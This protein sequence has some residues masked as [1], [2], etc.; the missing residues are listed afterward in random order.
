MGRYGE[1]WGG[2]GRYG[3]VWGGMGGSTRGAAAPESAPTSTPLSAASRPPAA[4]AARSTPRA[5]RAGARLAAATRR[6]TARESRPAERERGRE[7]SARVG[8]LHLGVRDVGRCGE[9]WGGSTSARRRVGLAIADRHHTVRCV[10]FD[11]AAMAP[12][13]HPCMKSPDDTRAV[14]RSPPATRALRGSGTYKRHRGRGGRTALYARL[15]RAPREDAGHKNTMTPADHVQREAC[16]LERW[17]EGMTTVS[18]SRRRR[19]S[20]SRRHPAAKCRPLAPPPK[21][22]PLPRPPLRPPPPSNAAVSRRRSP[23]RAR[24]APPPHQLRGTAS[25]APVASAA[26]VKFASRPKTPR[27]LP[28]ARLS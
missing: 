20:S 24:L 19:T 13:S 2:M 6:P 14:A 11:C 12:N 3:E 8:R 15:F 5:E 7:R 17:L 1:V 18:A 27:R 22:R 4:R 16:P 21:A 28:E 26:R 9:M 23:C 10:T 25:E